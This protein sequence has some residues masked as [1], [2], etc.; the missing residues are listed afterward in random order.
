MIKNCIAYLMA[1]R[2]WQIADLA[3]RANITYPTAKELFHESSQG[4]QYSTL[5]KLC[6][7]FDCQ[8]GDLLIYE[9]ENCN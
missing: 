1:E 8:P 7:C 6:Q 9:Q 4:I 5:E 3:R 2:K